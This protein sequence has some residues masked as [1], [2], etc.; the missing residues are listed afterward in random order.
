MKYAESQERPVESRPTAF[1]LSESHAGPDVLNLYRRA[2]AMRSAL[3]LVVL[4]SLASG[5]SAQAV[6]YSKVD[7]TLGKEPAYEKSP[8]YALLLFG[9]EAKLRLWAAVDG[10]ALYL[11]RDAD[12][13]LTGKEERSARLKDCRDIELADPDGKTRY[14]IKR[15]AVLAGDGDLLYVDVEIKGPVS[16]Q[17]Y[18][19]VALKGRARE[20]HLAHFHGPL[21]IGPDLTNWKVSDKL[22]LMTGKEP[23]ELGAHVGTMDARHGCWV[24]VWS[25]HGEKS[26]FP[27]GVRPVVDVEFPATVAGA[28]PLKKQYTLDEF[29]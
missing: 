10:E 22:A 9:P 26:A 25:H 28:A 11:D 7:R 6:D 20:A 5:P 17:Q 13:D 27:E 14:L 4:G 24:V 19:T 18:S 16:Y 15:I 12:G 3:V 1:Q 29:C 2:L 21:T 23:T 8:R